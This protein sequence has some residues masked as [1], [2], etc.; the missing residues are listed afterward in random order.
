[1]EVQLDRSPVV[2]KLK[3]KTEYFDAVRFGHKTAELRLDD[4]DF[5]IGDIVVLMEWGPYKGI[6]GIS[7][8][9][10]ITHITRLCYVITEPIDHRW[11]MLSLSQIPEGAYKGNGEDLLASPSP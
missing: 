2:H 8:A 6:T 1:M 10:E 5:R 4:R 11:V 7:V 3:I 9:K